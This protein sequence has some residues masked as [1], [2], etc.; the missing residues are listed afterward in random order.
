MI[1]FCN[2]HFRNTLESF[3]SFIIHTKRNKNTASDFE[4]I[5]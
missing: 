4:S 5:W 1:F 2:H 3:R